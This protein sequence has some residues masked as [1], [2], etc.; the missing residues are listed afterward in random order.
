MAN[1]R[2]VQRFDHLVAVD[3]PHAEIAA[4]PEPEVERIEQAFQRD[5]VGAPDNRVLGEPPCDFQRALIE[6][7]QSG[8]AL[9]IQNCTPL[10]IASPGAFFGV[11]RM[12][13]PRSICG[14][15]QRVR[16]PYTS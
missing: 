4:I 15:N 2:G 10:R 3:E 14:A 1:L 11:F 7:R 13:I 6:P 5:R 9:C 12:Q 8:L 16:S